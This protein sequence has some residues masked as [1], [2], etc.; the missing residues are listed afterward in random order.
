MNRGEHGFRQEVFIGERY[1]FTEGVIE[2]P[3]PELFNVEFLP[4]RFNEI[5]KEGMRLLLEIGQCLEELLLV[6]RME[7]ERERVIVGEA[8]GPGFC[9]PERHEANE[10]ARSA[11]RELGGHRPDRMAQRRFS[12]LPEH[13]AYV[14]PC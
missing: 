7:V 2:V 10:I 6:D 13:I 12:F 11:R 5:F 9:I 14:R 3:G 4:G 8:E 1:R